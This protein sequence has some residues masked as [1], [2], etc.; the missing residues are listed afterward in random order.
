MLLTVTTTKYEL[1]EA[2]SFTFF[3]PLVAVRRTLESLHCCALDIIT[4]AYVLYAGGLVPRRHWG[5]IFGRQSLS[6]PLYEVRSITV[7][8]SWLRARK[9]LKALMKQVV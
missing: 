8:Q 7:Y 3:V 9:C 1:V 2:S 6:G 4:R 5:I